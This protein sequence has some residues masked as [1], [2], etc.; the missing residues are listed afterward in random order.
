MKT[1]RL[2]LPLRERQ[3]PPHW[4]WID[5]RLVREDYMSRCEPEAWM[6]YLFLITVGDAQGLS[7]YSDAGIARRLDFT[8]QTLQE[9]R[10]QLCRADLVAYQKPLYQV[11]DL[12]PRSEEESPRTGECVSLGD[13]L[14]RAI[15]KA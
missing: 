5:H 3:L 4:S 9:A 12:G 15:E 10:K 2:I 14:R 7:Y 1:K 6:L 8:E 11:L 13:L